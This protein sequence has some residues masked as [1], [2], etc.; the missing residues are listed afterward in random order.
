M[1]VTEACADCR[2]ILACSGTAPGTHQVCDYGLYPSDGVKL[3]RQKPG[4]CAVSGEKTNFVPADQYP[5]NCRSLE[6]SG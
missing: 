1:C 3:C 4:V 5:H 2:L 6:K